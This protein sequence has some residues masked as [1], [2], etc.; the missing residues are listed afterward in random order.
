[1][2]AV[3]AAALAGC[4]CWIWVGS[5]ALAL[6]VLSDRAVRLPLL[7]APLRRGLLVACGVAAVAAGGPASADGPSGPTPTSDRSVLRGL[8]LPERPVIGEATIPLRDPVTAPG[9][10]PGRKVVVGPGDTLWDLAADHGPPGATAAEVD[11]AWR[12]IHAANRAV[13]GP[14]PDLIRPGTPLR[15]PP[16]VDDPKESR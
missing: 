10:G 8:P 11:A 1:M 16:P 14:D 15:L 13:I 3:C 4:L 2:A 6:D 9:A 7:P 5:T 12:R